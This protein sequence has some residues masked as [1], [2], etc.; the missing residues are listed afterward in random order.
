MDTTSL[1]NRFLEAVR[2]ANDMNPLPQ[3]VMLEFYAYYKQATTDNSNFSFNAYNQQ[4]LR[5]A[6][7]FNAWTQVKHLSADEAKLAYIELVEKH[8]KK[9]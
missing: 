6:F 2:I 1:H 8:S 7:K 5:T 3:D 4:D 9:R